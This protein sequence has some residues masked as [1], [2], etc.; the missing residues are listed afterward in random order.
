MNN[1]NYI[2]FKQISQNQKVSHY[3]QSRDN[4]DRCKY[5]QIYIQKLGSANTTIKINTKCCCLHY[6]KTK[7]KLV[8]TQEKYYKK[9]AKIDFGEI[10]CRTVHQMN[11]NLFCNGVAFARASLVQ[12]VG[13]IFTMLYTYIHC[14]TMVE[15]LCNSAT[16]I[17]DE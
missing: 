14:T 4:I 12:C 16:C 1:E 6:T 13:H 2:L 3:Q 11:W 17:E 9:L 5:V 15:G 8:F 7:S 10:S